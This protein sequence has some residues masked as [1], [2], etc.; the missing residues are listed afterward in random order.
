ME[1]AVV[2][3]VLPGPFGGAEAW[4]SSLN[5]VGGSVFE[6]GIVISCLEWQY[7]KPCSVCVCVIR[8]NAFACSKPL[9][10]LAS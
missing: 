6:Q 9:L 10:K 4:I 3:I 1:A 5:R 8:L 2:K 7:K